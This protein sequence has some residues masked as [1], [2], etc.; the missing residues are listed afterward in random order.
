MGNSA[1]KGEQ[2]SFVIFFC[3][4]LYSVPCTRFHSFSF[5]L[6]YV[7][8]SAEDLDLCRRF[9]SFP[10]LS[11]FLFLLICIFS[12]KFYARECGQLFRVIPF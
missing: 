6:F 7:I 12:F 11:L 5:I 8:Y 9:E 3:S 1:V 4:A 2:F 10:F